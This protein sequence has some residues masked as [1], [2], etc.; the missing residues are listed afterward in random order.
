MVDANTFAPGGA[1]TGGVAAVFN[2]K[3]N[4]SEVMFL[5]AGGSVHHF[6]VPGPQGW[7]HEVKGL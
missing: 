7:V 5:G 2:P 6:S 1:V 3:H 4:H